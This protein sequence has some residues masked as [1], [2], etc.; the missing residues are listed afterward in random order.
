F[1][2]FSGSPLRNPP[3]VAGLADVEAKRGSGTLLLDA[4]A[5]ATRGPGS[6]S[7]Q[8]ASSSASP[9]GSPSRGSWAATRWPARRSGRLD[10]ALPA[11]RGGGRRAGP[12]RAGAGPQRGAVVAALAVL[13]DVEGH[14]GPAPR[15]G[16]HARRRRGGLGHGDLVS[17]LMLAVWRAGAGCPA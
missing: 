15:R 10:V 9:S 6:T 1:A 16:P 5:G 3:S 4:V 12:C 8:G 17:A 11:R 2:G 7:T 13:A 14:D